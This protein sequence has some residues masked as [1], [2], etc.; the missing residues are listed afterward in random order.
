MIILSIVLG[1]NPSTLLGL[2]IRRRRVK[3]DGAEYWYVT[4]TTVRLVFELSMPGFPGSDFTDRVLQTSLTR[5]ELPVPRSVERV[6][7]DLGGLSP[8][9]RQPGSQL[10]SEISDRVKQLNP[11]FGGQDFKHLNYGCQTAPFV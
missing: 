8:E 5:I 1:R 2:P 3:N 9:Y 7:R 10:T 11:A 6:L 4:A